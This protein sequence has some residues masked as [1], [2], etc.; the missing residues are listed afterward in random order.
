MNQSIITLKHYD[1]FNATQPKFTVF[2]QPQRD[3]LHH[4]SKWNHLL[5]HLNSPN[6]TKTITNTKKIKSYPEIQSNS[7]LLVP[8]DPS[9]EHVLIASTPK[10]QLQKGFDSLAFTISVLSLKRIY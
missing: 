9:V 7:K 6:D 2:F 4:D 8:H 5:N 1:G 3:E 10:A